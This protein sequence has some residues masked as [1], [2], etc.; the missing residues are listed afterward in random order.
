MKEP[1][2]K[3]RSIFDWKAILGILLSAA[4]LYWAMRGVDFSQVLAEVRR[5]NI[6]LLLLSVALVTAV[7]PLRA[8][9]WK[10]L[11]EVAAPNSPFRARF[12]ATTIGFMGN[13]LLPAR[14]G[15]FAR[16]YALARQQNASMVAAFASLIAERLFDAV[17]LVSFLFL[18]IALPG[19]PQVK[20]LAGYDFSGMATTLGLIVGALIL[21]CLLLVL[22]PTRTV[23]FVEQRIAP[24]L[25][26]AVRRPLVDALAAFLAG[27][28]SLRSP[29]LMATLAFQT[30]VIWLVNG[31]GFWVGFMAFHIDVP[32]AGALFMQSVVALAVSLPSAPG[33][34]GTFE[35]AARIVLVELFLIDVNK[36]LGFALGFH[37]GGFIPVTLIGLYYAWRLGLSWREVEHSEETVEAAIEREL[38]GRGTT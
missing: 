11:L 6:G 2:G 14:I 25:P 19:F 17:A 10:P 16:A 22:W 31:L 12:A 7:F 28:G 26:R 8:W 15:E 35:Y 5:A 3:P 23:R 21:V 30:A 18:A 27:L 24:V 1:P 36:A 38:P 37:I 32:F 33:F 13:N 34:F 20:E 9:R 29:T 4:L